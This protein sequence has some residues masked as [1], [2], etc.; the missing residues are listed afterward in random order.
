MQYRLFRGWVESR[1]LEKLSMQRQD[2]IV[3]FGFLQVFSVLLRSY[4]GT[5]SQDFLFDR[6][7]I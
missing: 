4:L 2:A 7:R 1:S 3:A 6:A 5:L